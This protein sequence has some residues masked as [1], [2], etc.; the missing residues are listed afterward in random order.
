[1]E[2]IELGPGAV[3]PRP[4]PRAVVPRPKLVIRADGDTGSEIEMGEGSTLEDAIQDC[5]ADLRIYAK[6]HV[7]EGKSYAIFDEYDDLVAGVTCGGRGKVEIVTF[8][9]VR[10]VNLDGTAVEDDDDD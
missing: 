10:T 2:L 6:H 3:V 9:E 5:L 4:K 1:M 7:A 8:E